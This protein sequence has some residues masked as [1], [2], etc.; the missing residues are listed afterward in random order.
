MFSNHERR[1][2]AADVII[3]PGY[4]VPEIVKLNYIQVDQ[5]L[6]CKTTYLQLSSQEGTKHDRRTNCENY[7]THSLLDT[8]LCDN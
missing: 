1:Y 7:K 4:I 5:K 3:N 8:L 2:N 6:T